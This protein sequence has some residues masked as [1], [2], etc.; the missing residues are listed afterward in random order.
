MYVILDHPGVGKPVVSFYS[1]RLRKDGGE[2]VLDAHRQM[3]FTFAG[4]KQSL[5]KNNA[6]MAARLHVQ[7]EDLKAKDARIREL[8]ARLNNQ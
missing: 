1:P 6:D 5:K 8:E 2:A 3:Y 7:E 4:L